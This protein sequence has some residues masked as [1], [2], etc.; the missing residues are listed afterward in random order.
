[1]IVSL[2]ILILTTLVSVNS[3]AQTTCTTNALGDRTCTTVTSGTTTGNVLTN[4]TF[5]TGNT[6]TT[7]GWSSDGH[8][9][10][11]GNFGNFPYQSGM[12][13]SGGVW[14]GEGHTDDNIYQDV[15]LVGDGHLT[16]SQINEGFTSTQSADVWFWN[17][18]ENTFTLKQTITSSDGTVT[19]QTRV[20][21]DHDPSRPFNGG[22]FTNYTNVYTES[23]NSQNDYTIRAEMYNETAGTAYDNTHRGPDVDNVQLSITTAGT[24]TVVVTPC[25]VL[26]TCTSAGEDIA[27]AVD[28]T[29]DDGIDLFEDL[30]TKIEDAIEDF[31]EVEVAPIIETVLLIEDDFGEIEEIKLEELAE[32]VE[33]S[34]TEFIETNDLVETFEAELKVEGI[35]EEQFFEELGNEMMEEIGQEMM[36]EIIELNEPEMMEEPNVEEFKEEEIEVTSTEETN[37]EVIEEKPTEEVIEEKP[38]NTKTE[39]EPNATSNENE[40]TTE[41]STTEETLETNEETESTGQKDED[42]STESEVAENKETE[43]Q[44]EKESDVE[45]VEDETDVDVKDRKVVTK[46]P[47]IGK[48][49]ARIIKKLEA[50]LKRVDDKIKATSYVLAVTLQNLQP[51]MGSYINKSIPKGPNLNGIPNDDFFDNINRIAQQQIYKDASL[52]AYTSNDPIAVHNRL[53]VE[54]DSKKRDLKAEIAAL[55]S[56]LK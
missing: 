16:K 6:T 36:T 49:V 20:I 46:D 24:T 42:V 27:D 41:T 40:S 15:D 39:E 22:T 3:Q 25:A 26:G 2:T 45:A 19:T 23:A 5:G 30:D 50:K 32:F 12:D 48:K 33:A 43:G 10:T 53:L 54:I 55:R 44:T 1:M 7:T 11:H 31:E 35:T 29:T 4:S 9:H 51:D 52:N 17:N 21:N 47:E 14:A 56:L 34:F 37:E 18:I 28:L 8:K 13:T 38:T